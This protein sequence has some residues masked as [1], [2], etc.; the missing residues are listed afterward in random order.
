[1][2]IRSPFV[3]H[4]DRTYMVANFQ[5]EPTDALPHLHDL[6]ADLLTKH[7]PADILLLQPLSADEAAELQQ[8]LDGAE[9]DAW[10]HVVG[11]KK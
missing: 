4:G 10:A 2:K 1:M 7:D 3:R 6:L 5:L 11:S 8:A 9:V